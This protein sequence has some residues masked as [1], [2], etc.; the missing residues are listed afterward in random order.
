MG[1]ENTGTN[2]PS[3][4]AFRMFREV[5][6]V[7]RYKGWGKTMRIVVD[8]VKRRLVDLLLDCS[9][10]TATEYAILLGLI[11]LVSM[12]VLQMIGQSWETGIYVRLAQ[13][14]PN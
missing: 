14:I 3:T 6:V 12:G 2:L 8:A 10:P 7:T 5:S 11:V 4:E 1:K 13:A 9:G